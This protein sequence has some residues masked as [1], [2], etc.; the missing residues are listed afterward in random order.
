M[1]N[2]ELKLTLSCEWYDMIE[3]GIKKEEYREI[4]DYWVGRICRKQG[5][6]LAKKEI[7]TLCNLIKT[8]PLGFLTAIIQGGI[9]IHNH[10]TVTFYRGVPYFSNDVKHMT[11][12]IESTGIGIGNESWGA[13]KEHVFKLTLGG[14]IS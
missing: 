9:T 10:K 14:R 4:K 11:W 1:E 8:N 6:R 5:K 2:S 12:N 3:L 13:P 7:T